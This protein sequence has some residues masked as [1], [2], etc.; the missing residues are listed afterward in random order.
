[1]LDAS[2]LRDDLALL[3]QGSHRNGPWTLKGVLST[4]GKAMLYKEDHV[5]ARTLTLYLEELC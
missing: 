1:M 3:G 5:M 4:G 2:L